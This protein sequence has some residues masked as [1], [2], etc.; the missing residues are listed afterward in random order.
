VAHHRARVGRRE[1]ALAGG[2]ALL[3]VFLSRPHPAGQ[4]AAAGQHVQV[5]RPVTGLSPLLYPAAGEHRMP[6]TG[7]QGR[8]EQRGQHVVMHPRTT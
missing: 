5:V 6:L 3:A 2:R 4:H 7:G 1:A 8:V